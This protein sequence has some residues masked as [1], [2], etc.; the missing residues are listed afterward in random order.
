VVL[1]A[2][3]LLLFALPE[4]IP[5]FPAGWIPFFLS[6]FL[7]VLKSDIADGFLIDHKVKKARQYSELRVIP[8]IVN[9]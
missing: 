1:P 8:F 3:L 4:G 5:G 6:L 2:A 7:L 9:V